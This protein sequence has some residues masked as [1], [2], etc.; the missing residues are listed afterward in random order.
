MLLTIDEL[1]RVA[2]PVRIGDGALAMHCIVDPVPRVLVF[3][4]L[5]DGPKTRYLV[6]SEVSFVYRSVS[7]PQLAFAMLHAINEVS[8]VYVSLWGF[9]LPI[10]TYFVIEPV[11][12]VLGLVCL[13]EDAKA[14]ALI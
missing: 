2:S 10:A 14:V 1:P 9:E 6:I 3:F 11:A 5:L 8:G 7:K 12:T 4:R 13:L